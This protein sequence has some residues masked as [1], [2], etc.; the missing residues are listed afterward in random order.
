[1][2][3]QR[4]RPLIAH[5][6]YRF[7]IGGLENGVVNLINRLPES[8]WQHAV[9][10]LTEISSAF[11]KRVQRQDVRYLSLRKPP[12]HLLKLYPRLMRLFR[13]LQ[14]A[15]V[16]TR[17]LAA[18]E[19]VVPAWAVGI[20]A[21]IHG[22]H[23][24]DAIDP[25]G[26]RR[27]YQWVRRAYSPFVS[28]YVAVSEDLEHYLR[29]RVGIAADRIEQ[30]YNGVDA[31]RFYPVADVRADIDGCPFHRPEHWLVGTVGRMDHVKDQSA[32]ARAFVLAVR[33]H[34]DARNRMRLIV[35]GEGA[36]RVEAE[37]TLRDGGVRELT[38]FAGERN[39]IPNI[40]RGLDCFVLPSRGEGISNT[41]LEAMACALPVV[42]TRVGGNAE[43]VEDGLTGR[44]VPV[45][46]SPALAQAILG[47]FANP[48]L[49]RRQGRAARN[50][51]ERNFSLDRMVESYHQLY[52][53]ALRNSDHAAANSVSNLPSAEG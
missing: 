18:L 13:E 10:A 33:M 9:V 17:N 7:D 40:M 31:D 46:D 24:W 45:G 14:P 19:A 41:I 50:R 37:R 15:V 21:R 2:I 25:V 23:G 30:L 16:H 12:G 51:V 34:P 26:T 42:A 11:A 4:R 29:D 35:V 48:A 44:L 49:A 20:R 43:L 38:W 52:L 39:D 3:A 32:L 36:L 5:V 6:V 1:M 8:S 27:R 53:A 22:E 28:R 47:Y